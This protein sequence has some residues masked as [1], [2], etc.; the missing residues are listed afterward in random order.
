MAPQNPQNPNKKTRIRLPFEERKVDIGEWAY[1]HRVGLCV[2]L[3]AYLLLMIVFMSA[4]I[5][6]GVK[7]HQQGMYIDLNELAELEQIRDR[8][9][10]EV[11]SKQKFD[12]G[13]VQ[14]AT[15]N[16]NSMN[17]SSKSDRGEQMSELNNTAEQMQKRMAANR[18]E[19]E[20]GVAEAEAIRSRKGNQGADEVVEDRKVQGNV[21]VSFSL[22]NPL[23]HAR[24][25]IVPAYRCQGGGEVVVSITVDRSGRVIDAK[26]KR[27]GDNCMQ[28]TALDSARAST[29][30]S[31]DSAPVKHQGEITYI[32]I[33]QNM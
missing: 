15:S 19:Y 7:P 32:F 17:E 28:Q 29:F 10:E 27:G 21:T 13:S 30:D 3:I 12:W 18:E 6:V 1:R 22:N 9:K 20:R 2:T 5:M 33:P 31:N 23:R 26:I 11:E 4:K 24:N 25:L 14:N 16:E 8:L